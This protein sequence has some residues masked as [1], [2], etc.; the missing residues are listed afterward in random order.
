M[1]DLV[2]TNTTI[3]WAEAHRIELT[4]AE[5]AEDAFC[6]AALDLRRRAGTGLIS[7]EIILAHAQSREALQQMGYSENQI[8][9]LEAEYIQARQSGWKVSVQ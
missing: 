6:I 2:S 7:D 5:A 1:A 8:D 4:P 3:K 9:T